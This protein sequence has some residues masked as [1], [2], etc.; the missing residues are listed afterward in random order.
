[1]RS[2]QWI[3]KLA[4]PG[5]ALCAF[6]LSSPA[7]ALYKFCTDVHNNYVDKNLGED[8]LT[9]TTVRAKKHWMVVYKD[10]VAV[11]SSYL[12]SNGCSPSYFYAEGSYKTETFPAIEVQSGTYLWVYE[13]TKG[14]WRTGVYDYGWLPYNPGSTILTEV[15]HVGA[16]YSSTAEGVFNVSAALTQTLSPP[17]GYDV[18]LRPGTYH[19]LANQNCPDAISCYRRAD[20][21]LYLGFDLY[22]Y[23]WD[24]RSKSVIG[25]EMGHYVQDRLFGQPSGEAAYCN[26]VPA[27]LCR[28]DHV[29]SPG[30]FYCEGSVP[31]NQL[32]C[33][34]SRENQSVARS[35]GFAHFFATTL[36]NYP[37]GSD[38][39]FAYYKRFLRTD[40]VTVYPPV[41]HDPLLY[42][43]VQRWMEKN[44]SDQMA[45]LGTEVDWMGFLYKTRSKGTS[46]TRYTYSNLESVFE[47]TSVCNGTCNSGDT[48]TWAK[49]Y[50]AVAT[51]SP[52]KREFFRINGDDYGVNH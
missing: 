48:V 32:H 46:S 31:V 50:N 45:D 19:I 8:Y 15:G 25:H 13:N 4:A 22:T 38:A 41:K 11:S 10:N 7:V 44:C 1:M 42:T 47:S 12:D 52:T 34:Q 18:G 36:F 9:G 2:T 51:Y 29:P 30:P 20:D 6:L 27:T 16:G 40:G 28:C 37:L 24:N 49:L 39:I 17:S 23:G 5:A 21:V 3:L 14:V 43:G 35:E 26:V 33:L